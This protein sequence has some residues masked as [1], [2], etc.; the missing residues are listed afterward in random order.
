MELPKLDAVSGGS[1]EVLAILRD[2][3]LVNLVLML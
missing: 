2:L 1:G 3:N